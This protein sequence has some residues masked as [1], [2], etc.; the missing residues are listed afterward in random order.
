[1][2]NNQQAMSM[3]KVSA[4]S[5]VSFGTSGARGLVSEMSPFVCAAYTQAFLELSA[6]KDSETILIGMDLRP[7]SPDIVRACCLAAE[8]A[9]VGVEFCGVLP[10]PALASY[11]QHKGLP[12][13]MVTGSHIP[14]DRNGIKFY[15][16]DGEISKD[17]EAAIMDATVELPEELV[18]PAMPNEEEGAVSDYLQRYLR[19]FPKD[20]L[21]G[22]RLGFY[23]HSSVARDMLS[24]LL[25]AL[26][27]EVVAL[28]RTDQFV[29]I[30]TEAVSDEDR[31]RG[32]KW[33]R[34][35]ALDALLSTDGD[36]DRP[37][38]GDE[39]GE[40]LRG[41]VVGLLCARYLGA[42]VVVTP[43]SCSTSI[44]RCGA[45]EHVVRTRIG[46]PYVIA[47]MEEAVAQGHAPVVGFEANGGFLVGSRVE[48]DGVVLEPLPTRDAALPTLALLVMAKQRGVPLSKLVAELPQRFTAS[49]RLQNFS[50]ERSAAVLA[51]LGEHHDILSQRYGA[52]STVDVTDGQRFSFENGEVIHLRP[53][54]NAP[55][56]RCYAE[57]ESEA[58]AA[59]LVDEVLAMVAERW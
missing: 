47:G 45:F 32:V 22:L 46:S 28:E 44:E 54:G 56:L 29:P 38:I 26:G 49:D 4:A 18:L 17:D 9:G 6:C 59:Q 30:D 50:R 15:R 41:D 52:V 19:F 39:H 16:P 43:V 58:R 36:A 55:E 24:R 7:S 35:Y 1:M 2:T 23:Q 42:S 12:A 27:A 5:G 10:T 34:E 21:Q 31:Q 8:L 33:S 11:A 13:I 20:I 14:F 40:W 53:S 48:R 51:S 37:L 25:E 57:A 3:R